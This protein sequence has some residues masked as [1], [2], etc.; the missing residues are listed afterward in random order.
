MKAIKDLLIKIKSFF[1][2]SDVEENRH[3]KNIMNPIFSSVIERDRYG[4]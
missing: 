2:K 1:I 3:I 4:D